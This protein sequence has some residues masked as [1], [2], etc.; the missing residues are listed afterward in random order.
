[1]SLV[2][3]GVPALGDASFPKM[4]EVVVDQATLKVVAVTAPSLELLSRERQCILIVGACAAGVV[5]W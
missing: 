2:K 1:M 3:S 4:L 5:M